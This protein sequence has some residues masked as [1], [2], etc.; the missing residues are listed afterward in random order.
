MPFFRIFS[1][2]RNVKSNIGL[3]AKKCE[4]AKFENI[5]H[6]KR[7]S[8]KNFLMH[9]ETAEHTASNTAGNTAEHT[10]EYTAEH[11]AEHTGLST[12]LA[13]HS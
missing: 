13:E 4:T 1:F 11:T 2:P 6:K 12:R 5:S 8:V 3:F 7:S 9:V 10:A